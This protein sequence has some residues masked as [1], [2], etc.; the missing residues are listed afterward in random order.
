MIKQII[1]RMRLKARARKTAREHFE[2]EYS[3]RRICSTSIRATE[4]TRFVIAVFYQE[5]ETVKK[6]SPYALFA[7]STSKWEVEE[8]PCNPQSPFWIRGRK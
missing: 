6:P 1:E 3:N 7:V 8:L 2:Q 4:E 5:H